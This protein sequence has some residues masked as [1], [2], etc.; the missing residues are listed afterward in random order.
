MNKTIA[1]G[2]TLMMSFAGLDSALGNTEP[3]RVVL[4]RRTDDLL[5][6]TRTFAQA[7]PWSAASGRPVC[8]RNG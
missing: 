3:L 8:L 6:D 7:I 4:V 5:E 2:T 1:I